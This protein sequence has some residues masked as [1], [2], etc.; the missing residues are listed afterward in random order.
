MVLSDLI[1][2]KEWFVVTPQKETPQTEEVNKEEPKETQQR[3]DDIIYIIMINNKPFGYFYD[4]NEL[5]DQIKYT[6]ESISQTHSYDFR[7]NYFWEEC[8]VEEYTDMIF[9]LKLY[10]N[11]KDFQNNYYPYL[12][13]TVEILKSTLIKPQKSSN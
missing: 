6:K 8:K 11:L 2:I 12:E 1:N 13:D 5:Q 3:D 10:S 4:L 7:K 9:K